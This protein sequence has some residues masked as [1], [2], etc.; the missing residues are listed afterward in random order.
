MTVSPC[1]L[2][3]LNH[4]NFWYNCLTSFLFL[5]FLLLLLC[6]SSSSMLLGWVESPGYPSGYPPH[7][8]LNWSRCAPEGHI[9][10]LKLIHLDLEDSHDCENDALKVRPLDERH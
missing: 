7:A 6:H 4:L 2:K 8:T 5:S 10:S 9:L 1:L 3:V